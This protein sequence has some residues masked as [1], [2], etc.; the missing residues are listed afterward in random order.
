MKIKNKTLH[1]YIVNHIVS[2][3]NQQQADTLAEM[4]LTIKD[5]KNEM[6]EQCFYHNRNHEIHGESFRKWAAFNA[7]EQS[8]IIK[9]ARNDAKSLV[10]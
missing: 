2:T 3:I 1:D 9:N 7:E 4:E 10:N 5:L 6:R 8:Q